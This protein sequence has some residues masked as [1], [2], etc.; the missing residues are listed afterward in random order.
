MSGYHGQDREHRC[1]VLVRQ[2]VKSRDATGDQY[3]QHPLEHIQRE[4]GVAE[5]LAQGTQ[6]VS[7]ANI[8][9]P[10]IADVDALA[11]ANEQPEGNP[12]DEIAGQA[13]D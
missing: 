9:A 1:Q 8:A 4:A 2:L 13:G 5:S 3:W 6:Y 11:L 10:V 12:A 7:G